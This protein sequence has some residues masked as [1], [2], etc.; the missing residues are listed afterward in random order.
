MRWENG[1]FCSWL[2]WSSLPFC[3]LSLTYTLK[4]KWYVWLLTCTSWWGIEKRS[5]SAC[6][7]NTDSPC[8]GETC[9]KWEN[10]DLEASKKH[11]P[12]P[13]SWKTW[14][15]KF[16]KKTTQRCCSHEDSN[17]EIKHLNGLLIVPM[18]KRK[19]SIY[20]LENE[21]EKSSCWMKVV[22]SEQVV[23]HSFWSNLNES[24]V[25][26]DETVNNIFQQELT[27]YHHKLAFI[28]PARR[29]AHPEPIFFHSTWRLMHPFGE[30]M[31]P[32]R[33]DICLFWMVMVPFFWLTWKIQ[34]AETLF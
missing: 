19:V 12:G 20:V 17:V 25:Y 2:N 7:G 30:I 8:E 14:A 31:S 15:C 26:I 6:V 1:V 10:P 9:F 34:D 13:K 21:S 33:M 27:I 5:V 29:F 28:H 16:Q 4:R 3:Q 22:G 18:V 24:T 23:F 32:F 11:D